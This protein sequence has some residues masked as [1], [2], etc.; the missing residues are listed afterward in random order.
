MPA[1]QVRE[2]HYRTSSNEAIVSS[3]Q[4][5]I[6]MEAIPEMRRVFNPE[7]EGL[8]RLPSTGHLR[9]RR[10]ALGVISVFLPPYHRRINMS[11]KFISFQVHTHPSSSPRCIRT[12]RTRPS[13]T[14]CLWCSHMLYRRFL[15]VRCFSLV[16]HY[17]LSL[18]IWVG[19]CKSYRAK[20]L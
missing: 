16:I 3:I 19:N 9:M 13:P 20:A 18:T 7:T 6:N 10:S 1:Y 8:S 5:A 17:F 15:T 14:S 12:R 2:Q 4:Q 11:S